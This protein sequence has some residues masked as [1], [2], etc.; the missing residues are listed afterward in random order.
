MVA[1]TT[2]SFSAIGEEIMLNVLTIDRSRGAIYAVAEL[3]ERGASF[4]DALYAVGIK[5]PNHPVP[6][7]REGFEF[8]HQFNPDTNAF[9]R[10]VLL[11][12]R[13]ERYPIT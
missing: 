11:H 7:I 6:A 13:S 12:F 9:D 1:T 8:G 4:R 2:T 10:I 5:A 3:R